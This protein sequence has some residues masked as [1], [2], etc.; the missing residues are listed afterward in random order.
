M[1]TRTTELPVWDR[2]TQEW[3][4]PNRQKKDESK[5]AGEDVDLDDV[6]DDEMLTNLDNDD[7]EPAPKKRSLEPRSFSVRKWVPIPASEA[8]KIPERKFLA[9]RRSGMP[10]LYGI[11]GHG[12]WLY[13][14]YVGNIGGLGGRATAGV[15]L[16][17]G[18]GLGDAP[19]LLASQTGTSTPRKA[20]PPRRKKKKGGP[21]R[22]KN[23][24]L[25]AEAEA[26][27]L[28]ALGTD[29]GAEGQGDMGGTD[30]AN[31]EHGEG[32][33]DHDDH[34]DDHDDDH[35][36]SESEEEGSEEGEVRTDDEPKKEAS[37]TDEIMEDVKEEVKE[38]EVAEPEVVQSEVA[39]PEVAKSEVAVPENAEPA[40][41]EPPSV[42]IVEVNDKT[43]Q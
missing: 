26:R 35:S 3:C 1:G 15:D 7:D 5:A 42:P 11:N 29:G 39:E 23:S 18:S 33:G 22:K 28:A 31:G 32:H 43:S 21:G 4:Y 13:Q 17:D 20:P 10:S 25:A 27:R 12:Q 6:G 38:P 41:A 36:G 19:G 24:V 16:G 14:G 40:D 34:D 37:K 2:K 9:D 8:E 30:A